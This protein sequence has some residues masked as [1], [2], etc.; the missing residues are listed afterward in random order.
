MI[1]S[2]SALNL[3]RAPIYLHMVTKMSST[4][5]TC[6]TSCSDNTRT[7]PGFPQ[8]LLRRARPWV[9]FSKA[10]PTL[11]LLCRRSQLWCRPSP[12]ALL[13]QSNLGQSWVNAG[14]E[15]YQLLSSHNCDATWLT[16]GGRLSRSRAVTARLSK[17][18]LKFTRQ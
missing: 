13:G 11:S 14:V 5:S 8:T 9:N 1:S 16:A 10:P 4:K 6:L 17:L 18:P 15:R 7:T 3:C 12:Q 2:G